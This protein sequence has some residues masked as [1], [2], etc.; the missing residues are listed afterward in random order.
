MYGGLQN[1]NGLLTYFGSLVVHCLF[2]LY[3]YQT[4]VY[5]DIRSLS[6]ARH[7]TDYTASVAGSTPNINNNSRHRK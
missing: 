4:R 3:L 1:G 7:Y 2:V 6:P 5:R